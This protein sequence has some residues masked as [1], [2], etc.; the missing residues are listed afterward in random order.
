MWLV[1]CILPTFWIFPVQGHWFSSFGT[2]FAFQMHFTK[3]NFRW[4]V[5]KKLCCVALKAYYFKMVWEILPITHTFEIYFWNFSLWVSLSCTFSLQITCM[6]SL[7]LFYVKI[8]AQTTANTRR[9]T[10]VM[11]YDAINSTRYLLYSWI[12]YLI[13]TFASC[14]LHEWNDFCFLRNSNSIIITD[15][16]DS[17]VHSHC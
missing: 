12:Y 14:E 11:R 13:V 1:W 15:I 8:R 5:L 16:I 9:S 6:K 3:V 17:W 7:M 10:S 4:E 2:I